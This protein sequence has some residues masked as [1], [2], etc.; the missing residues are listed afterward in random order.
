MFQEYS[1]FFAVC[2]TLFC[3]IDFTGH[4]R[5]VNPAWKNL[6]YPQS[7]NDLYLNLVH[8][9]DHATTTASLNQLKDTEAVTLVNRFR[10]AD[11]NY[12]SIVWQLTKVTEESAYYAVGTRYEPATP[13]PD[14]LAILENLQEA[15]VMQYAD[16]QV[17]TCN[18]R[19]EQI[20]ETSL[21]PADFE[22]LWQAAN[23]DSPTTSTNERAATLYF[24]TNSGNFLTL[25][26][27]T[28]V[29]PNSL[30][31]INFYDLTAQTR[32]EKA[33]RK[34]KQDTNFILKIRG[35]G[36]LEWDLRTGQVDY[37][38][39]WKSLLGYS[40]ADLGNQINGW[41]SR[42][43]LADHTSV[44]KEIKNCLEG[45]TPHYDK[46]HRLQH[47]DGSYRWMHS[48]GLVWRDEK[49]QASRLL[50]TFADITERKRA[51]Q[52][53]ETSNKYGQ[54][55]AALAEVL[56]FIDSQGNLIEANNTAVQLYG[57]PRHELL[58]LRVPDLFTKELITS[59]SPTPQAT[60]HKRKDGT[61]LPVEVIINP[62]RWQG[63]K[64]FAVAARDVKVLREATTTLAEKEAYYRSLFEAVT[65][66]IVIFDASSYQILDVNPPAV[67]LYGY[68]REKYRQFYIEDLLANPAQ[69]VTSLRSACKQKSLK[70]LTDWHRKRDGQIFP[71][72]MSLGSYPLNQRT[73]VGAIVR[74]VTERL[75][76]D[77]LRKTLEFTNA[78]I[79]ALPAF[80]VTLTPTGKIAMMNNAFLTALGY[81]K[82][83]VV[84]KDYLTFLIPPKDRPLVNNHLNSLINKRQEKILTDISLLTK[85][86]KRL[87]TECHCCVTQN[88]QGQIEYLFA[89]GI[90]RTKAQKNIQNQIFKEIVEH[91]NEAIALW[92]QNKSLIYIN[93]AHEKLF[94]H[95]IEQARK[96]HYRDYFPPEVWLPVNREIRPLLAKP[97]KVWEG[98]LHMLDGRGAPVDVW[99]CFNVVHDE[100]DN[101]LY[102]FAIMHA[103]DDKE[104]MEAALHYEHE[105]YETLLQAAPLSI[106]YKD[107]E[108][109]IIR[110]NR[111]AAEALK[112]TPQQL[113]GRSM[114]DL[115][116]EHAK[117]YHT[118]DLEVIYSGKPKVGIVERHHEGFSQ[119]D[120]VP[121]RDAQGNIQG[122]IIFSIN[123][124]KRVKTIEQALRQ[125]QIEGISGLR[126]IMETLPIMFYAIDHKFNFLLW[127]RECE[128]LTGY[129]ADEIVDNPQAWELLCPEAGYREEMLTIT[130]EMIEN[131]A[132]FREWEWTV[133]CK[134][135]PPKTIVWSGSSEAE[136]MGFALCAV[137]RDITEHDQ[138]LQLLCDNEERLRI[139]IENMPV[140]FVAYSEPGFFVQWNHHCET[141]TGYHASEIIRNPKALELLYPDSEYREKILKSQR[142]VTSFWRWETELVSKSGET[143]IIAW[144]NISK[145]F[146]MPGWAGWM[147]GE[148]ITEFRSTPALFKNPEFLL[149]SLLD[150]VNIAVGVTDGR[151][152]FVYV[153]RLYCQLY[154]YEDSELLNAKFPLVIPHNEHQSAELRHYFRFMTNPREN[155]FNAI[156]NA[157][158][159][160][161]HLFKVRM[162]ARRVEVGQLY[163]V[164]TVSETSVV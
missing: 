117:E 9:E 18:P 17:K 63:Q 88:Q 135:G 13:A 68:P 97:G 10:H 155:N 60:Y 34:I 138:I 125:R 89:I 153:N 164:W 124:T 8:P 151:G 105:R 28:Q 20:L 82:E 106:V 22:Q 109:R 12:S 33:L 19:E 24:Q 27:R 58:Q 131:Y 150:G 149:A 55:F 61:L 73:L 5:H 48:R 80:F 94:K 71:I 118:S 56:L 152:R 122:V 7:P 65:D 54:A 146:P 104:K 163:V 87:T 3:V 43:H 38:S 78:L 96:S 6:G 70:I 148:D 141:I 66:A 21:K 79:Q 74:D 145:D 44:L 158:H 15:V 49:G 130:K 30:R 23:K 4:V 126:L 76:T 136:T 91:S 67:K 2:Q 16:G 101:L 147:I 162:S 100:E 41:Y 29:L 160:D 36:L 107:K 52:A 90:N 128:H 159:H 14:L 46:I 115:T 133:N 72:E 69:S 64:M 129:S 121:Y 113:E 161:G 103:V 11:G 42:I 25:A 99:S 123:I 1:K 37:S 154:G 50:V 75:S 40:E 144:S 112:M 31:V 93:Q 81:T 35:E 127:N 157:L 57:Y 132:G 32:L 59:D 51:E 47:K 139:L 62:F 108:N 142:Q 114:Y 92:G 85:E 83:E 77:E 26:V 98:V 110:A 120:K 53:L 95:S 134:E 119:V 156:W 143:K 116:P 86:G 140:L 111:Y 84:G 102:I 137:G 45:L 39:Q